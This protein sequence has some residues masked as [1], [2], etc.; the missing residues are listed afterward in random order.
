LSLHIGS[1]VEIVILII[2]K[3]HRYLLRYQIYDVSINNK[4]KYYRTITNKWHFYM[5]FYNIGILIRYKY[6][7]LYVG[8]IHQ[9]GL[10][11]G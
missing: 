7:R 4:W 5:D 2:G 9:I 10:V 8:I 1:V 11:N 3:D 6:L